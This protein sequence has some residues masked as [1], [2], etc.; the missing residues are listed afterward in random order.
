MAGFLIYLT[1]LQGV[2]HV[3]FIF[4]V[5]YLLFINKF[6]VKLEKRELNMLIIIGLMVVNYFIFS[7][8]HKSYHG[9]PK[10]LFLI[11]T[12]LIAKF[13]SKNDLKV[14]LIFILLEALIAVTQHLMGINSFFENEFSKLH[15]LDVDL[16]YFRRVVG[17]SDGPTILSIKFLVAFILIKFLK[18]NLKLY[19]ALSVVLWL[20]LIFTFSRAALA[21]CLITEVLFILFYLPM[22]KRNKTIIGICTS[23]LIVS[24]LIYFYPQISQQFFRGNNTIEFSGRE[25]IWYEYFKYLSDNWLIGNGSIKTY[26][27]VPV[28]GVMQ[29]HNSYIQFFATN[30]IFIS[31]IF[32]SLIL[33]YVNRRNFIYLIPIFIFS[34][35]NYGIFWVFSLIDVVFYKF[36][37]YTDK[38]PPVRLELRIPRIRFKWPKLVKFESTS[39]DKTSS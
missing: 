21:A 4:I 38:E 31:I 37:F 29:A 9:F 30:G 23:V 18:F 39:T 25:L 15:E 22:S 27:D 32:F 10:F 19:F 7:I 12:V 1:T 20:S 8:T 34:M 16:L 6:K 14:L 17:L 13:I 11:G 35:A 5:F 36:L 28:Y 3:S 24:I 33:F 26:L 2:P